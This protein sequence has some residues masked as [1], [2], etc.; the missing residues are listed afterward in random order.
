[1]DK[2][3]TS[4]FQKATD[5]TKEFIRQYLPNNSEISRFI[6][7]QR[8]DL[9]WEVEVEVIEESAYFKKI[10]A[11][12]PVWEKNIY[13]IIFDSN[14]HPLSYSQRKPDRYL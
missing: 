5:K 8:T 9:G 7:V 1:M 4:N 11:A 12:E 10:G 13:Q 6:E 2:K 14:F 3:N